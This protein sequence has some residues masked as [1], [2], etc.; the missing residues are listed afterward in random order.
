RP[1]SRPS[2]LFPL[3][4]RSGC[5]LPGIL[6]VALAAAEKGRRETGA[7]HASG[8]VARGGRP[9]PCWSVLPVPPATEEA[10]PRQRYLRSALGKWR[11]APPFILISLLISLTN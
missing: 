11:E 5:G 1:G 3:A 7:G 6:T 9:S 2:P 8:E 4:F 10:R